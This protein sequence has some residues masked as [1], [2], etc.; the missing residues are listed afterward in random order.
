[1]FG[2]ETGEIHFMTG[3]PVRGFGITPY[4][5]DFPWLLEQLGWC[6]TYFA[7]GVLF[8]QAMREGG[9]GMVEEYLWKDLKTIVGLYQQDIM[10]VTKDSSWQIT[11][12]AH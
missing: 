10:L 4:V 8:F 9:Y 5:T 12:Q 6:E 7:K 11:L 1:M 2:K 3:A